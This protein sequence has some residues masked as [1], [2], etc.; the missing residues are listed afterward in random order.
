MVNAICHLSGRQRQILQSKNTKCEG[1]GD[2]GDSGDSRDGE[3]ERRRM[4]E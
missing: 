1:S 3:P 2:S 4:T